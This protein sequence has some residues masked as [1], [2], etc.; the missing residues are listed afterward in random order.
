[1]PA[2]GRKAVD[3]G[4]PSV[5]SQ[6]GLHLLLQVLPLLLQVLLQMRADVQSCCPQCRINQMGCYIS[7]SGSFPEWSRGAVVHQDLRRVPLHSHQPCSSIV[8]RADTP[9][10]S[11]QGGWAALVRSQQ[12]AC[13]TATTPRVAVAAP[14]CWVQIVAALAPAAAECASTAWN[15]GRAAVPG[16]RGAAVDPAADVELLRSVGQDQCR[17]GTV[18]HCWRTQAA[19]ACL[20]RFQHYALWAP[21]RDIR[22]LV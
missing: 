2:T 1:M 13:P 10:P 9:R 19:W 21:A 6:A 18:T 14:S 22:H 4:L 7:E 3:P 8:S 15:G 20:P 12:V 17:D 16:L 5:Q 11:D